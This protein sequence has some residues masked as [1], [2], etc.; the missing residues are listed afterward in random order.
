MAQGIACKNS[1][2]RRRKKRVA[3]DELVAVVP[4][5][6][7][8]DRV[9]LDVPA[10]VIPVG[11]HGPEHSR[12]LRHPCLSFNC[13]DATTHRMFSGLNLIWDL[14]VLQR[15]VP[16][17][18]LFWSC[19]TLA[20]VWRTSRDSGNTATRGAARKPWPTRKSIPHSSLYIKTKTLRSRPQRGKGSEGQNRKRKAIQ[21][22]RETNSRPP[23]HLPGPPTE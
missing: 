8:V 10:V 21:D 9:G 2:R 23:L 16:I 13:L 22:Q 7:V 1:A 20:R 12:T 15:D 14:K 17:L 18:F 4:P 11:V 3:G 5:V 6:R 19:R